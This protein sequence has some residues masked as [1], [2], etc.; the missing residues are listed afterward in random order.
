MN[1]VSGESTG[2]INPKNLVSCPSKGSLKIG[3]GPSG[4]NNVPSV[5]L[6]LKSPSSK[7]LIDTQEKNRQES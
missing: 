1:E 2:S 6:V 4:L 3:V 7:S 5:L